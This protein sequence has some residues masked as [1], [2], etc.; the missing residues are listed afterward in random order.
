M[1]YPFALVCVC[2]AIWRTVRISSA[3]RFISAV[4]RLIGGTDRVPVLYVVRVDRGHSILIARP[5]FKDT[6]SRVHFTKE[7]S[8]FIKSA[9]RPVRRETES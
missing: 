4:D 5:G 6:P 9:C 8:I 3:R 2:R 1:T 7:S